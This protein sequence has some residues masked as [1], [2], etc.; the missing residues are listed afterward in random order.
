[1]TALDPAAKL[2]IINFFALYFEVPTMLFYDDLAQFIAKESDKLAK[3]ASANIPA[4]GVILE[5]LAPNDNQAMDTNP[6][7][8]LVTQQVDRLAIDCHGVDGDRHRG[9]T[10]P[11]TGREAPLY[12]QTGVNITNRRQIFAISPSDCA[13]LSRRLDVEVTPQLLGANLV[14]GREDGEHFSLS[15]VPLNSYL[16]IAPAQATE[17][18]RPPIATLI[19]YVQQKGCGRTGR[20]IA[21]A[22]GDASLAPRF[23]AHARDHRG[24]LC[25]VEYP[26][27]PPALLERGQ[28][29]FFQFPMGQCN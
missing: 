7:R 6:G 28:K 4:V 9:L 26:V 10:R 18:P 12:K 16:A 8:H 5:V 11:S 3:L 1:L 21:R 23:V 20:A 27:D 17:L 24:I 29:V 22:Y 25:S 15:A 13:E 19:P 2:L 14:I